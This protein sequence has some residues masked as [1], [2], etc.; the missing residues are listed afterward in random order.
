MDLHRAVVLEVL[1][2]QL[3][4]QDH[5]VQVLV[6]AVMDLMQ[7]EVMQALVEEASSVVEEQIQMEVETMTV[8][9]EEALVLLGVILLKQ[10]F[11][12]VITCQKN[13]LLMQQH[14]HQVLILVM[15]KQK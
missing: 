13:T 10:V 2:L 11:H 8:E 15:V 5:I 7:A 9:A 3:L 1:V 6:K 14:I 4:L 12:Q